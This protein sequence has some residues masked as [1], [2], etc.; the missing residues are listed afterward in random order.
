MTRILTQSFGPVNYPSLVSLVLTMSL[1]QALRML[2]SMLPGVERFRTTPSYLSSET[3]PSTTIE[4]KHAATKEFRTR[5]YIAQ[6][7]LRVC[8]IPTD[9]NIADFFT[10]ALTENVQLECL[11]S[12]WIS[13]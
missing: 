2:A 12:S 13:M 9:M 3:V 4:N 10:K 8:Y 7:L 5:Q 1:R 11:T 6:R